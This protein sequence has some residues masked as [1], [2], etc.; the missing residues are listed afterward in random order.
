MIQTIGFSGDLAN[1]IVKTVLDKTRGNPMAAAGIHIILPTRRACLIVKKAFL[2]ESRETPLLLPKL[3]PLYDLDVLNESIPTAL[4]PL[5][6]TLLLAHLC[7]KKPSVITLDGA[8]KIAIGLGEILDEFYQFEVQTTNLSTLVQNP[9]FAEHWNETL[10]FLNIITEEWP[11]ILKQMNKIDETDRRIRLIN[12]YT[13]QI[14]QMNTPVIAAGLDGGLPSVRR[15]LAAIQKKENGLVLLEGIDPF[16]SSDEYRVINENHYHHGLKQILAALDKQPWDI[17]LIGH[18]TEREN[19]MIEA[20]KPEQKTE[21]WQHAHINPSALNDVTRIDCDTTQDEA[22]TIALILRGVLDQPEKTATLVTPDRGLAKRV[23][24]EMKRWN[25]TLDDSGGTPVSQTEVGV[26]FRLIAKVGET[27]GDPAELLALLKHPLAADGKNP[28]EFRQFIRQTEKLARKDQKT[29]T[30]LLSTNISSFIS[31]FDNNISVP[32]KTFLSKHIQLAETLATSHDR[33]G[34]ERLWQS[35]AGQTLF[36]FLT[37]LSEQADLIG[38]IEPASYSAVLDIL[39]NGLNIRS[40]YGMHPRLDILGPIE[41]R[42]HHADVCIIGGLNEGTFPTLPETGPWLNRPMRQTLGLPAPETKIA[43]TAMDFAHCF[44]APTVFLTRAKKAEGSETIPSRFLS[45]LEAVLMGAN[46]PF[47]IQTN[48][49]ASALDTPESLAKVTRPCP[50]PP[51]SARPRQLSV[52]Q[53]ETWM[54][55]PYAIYARHILNLKPLEALNS[56]QKQRAYGLAVHKILE[57]YTQKKQD[58]WDEK[59]MMLLA[60]SVFDTVGM[61]I[62]DKIFYRPRFEQTARFL[63]TS[64]NEV[65][66]TVKRIL[67][68]QNAS[69][70]IDL[71]NDSF[72]LTGRLDRL[73]ILKD[74]TVRI[75]DYKT[76][77]APSPKEVLAGYAPQLPLEAYLVQSGGCQNLSPHSVSELSYW[78]LASKETDCKTIVLTKKIPADQ[79]I[80]HTVNGLKTLIEVFNHPETPYEACPV[81][82]KEPTYN[83]YDYLSRSAEWAHESE[84]S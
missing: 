22:L 55:N 34:I 79:L 16:L 76:G 81:A 72:T 21:E 6:R 2:R 80:E 3:L 32:F 71:G 25:I 57:L 1:H 27:H 75:L 38:L 56:D 13:E 70:T 54:R 10:T 53:I 5:E 74:G 43:T 26:F 63:C 83:D 58:H 36:E 4:P 28:T 20:L 45:R 8:L 84:S 51:V 15:L 67:V 14:S 77:G 30:P 24:D 17:P 48:D 18:R 47:P 11:K 37:Y 73:D 41:A 68:E 69:L 64:Q 39:M 33:T 60:D 65:A 35:D 19:L 62:T 44:C 42:F 61:S 78:K 59:E 50:C 31:L 9:V 40:N 49:W 52:T 7:A 29:F 46:I 66:D 12:A 23:I 82:G